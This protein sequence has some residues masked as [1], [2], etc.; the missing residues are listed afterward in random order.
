[1]V[2]AVVVVVV[3]GGRGSTRGTE[4]RDRLEA[5]RARSRLRRLG[6]T[7]DD[8]VSDDEVGGGRGIVVVVLGTENDLLKVKLKLK[9]VILGN[10]GRRRGA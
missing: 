9:V 8:G 10:M 3:I 2:V 1:M 7:L 6:S 4:R 5:R